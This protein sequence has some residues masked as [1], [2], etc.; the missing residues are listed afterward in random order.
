MSLFKTIQ[1]FDTSVL[2]PGTAIDYETKTVKFNGLITRSDN[3]ILEIDYYDP[4]ALNT[5]SLMIALDDVVKQKVAINILENTTHTV[6]DTTPPDNVTGVTVSP[7][8]TAVV[9]RWTNPTGFSDFNGVNIYR[10]GTLVVKN[11]VNTT[12]TDTSLN[13]GQTY[14]YIIKSTDLA[15]NE[16]DGITKV[17][18]TLDSVPPSDV[19]N[20]RGGLITTTSI[21][22]L[23]D[24]PTDADF[25]HLV[26]LRNNVQI[27]NSVR[28]PAF[29]DNGLS[30]GQVYNYTVIAVDL[31]G[32]QTAGVDI[33]LSAL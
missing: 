27:A 15:D 1:V 22:L 24:L 31:S 21:E 26:I 3:F 11:L 23:Y 32:N 2:S 14:T 17:T 6:P 33:S 4:S 28:T 7:N 20:L 29:T 19:A 25:D 9:L 30:T 16:S 10:D 8:Y 18:T 13:E 5:G 12:F